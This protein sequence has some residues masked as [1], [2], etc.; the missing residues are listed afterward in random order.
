MESDK[1]EQ[2]LEV[3]TMPKY[4]ALTINKIAVTNT[5]PAFEYEEVIV[6]LDTETLP[7]A[8]AMFEQYKATQ[9][10]QYKNE[11]GETVTIRFHKLVE[12]NSFLFDVPKK[13]FAE[14][15]CRY[16]NDYESY[17]KFDVLLNAE[18]NEKA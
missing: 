12:I 10:H 5:Q 13:G 15:F 8:E 7:E 16:F 17:C 11:A 18:A 9:N 3:F 14:I 4:Y 2:Q 6:A 1:N